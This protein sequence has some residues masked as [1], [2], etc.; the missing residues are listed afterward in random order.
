[1]PLNVIIAIGCRNL[2]RNAEVHGKI[3]HIIGN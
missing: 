2:G 3:E 1:M